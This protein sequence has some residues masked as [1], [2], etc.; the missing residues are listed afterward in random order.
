MGVIVTQTIAASD[1]LVL[2][3]LMVVNHHVD[4]GNRILVLWKS[5]QYS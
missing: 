4:S 3:L 2:V 1:P 5:R